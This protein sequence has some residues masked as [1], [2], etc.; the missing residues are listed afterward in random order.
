MSPE[1][2]EDSFLLRLRIYHV[3]PHLPCWTM[4]DGYLLPVDFI[5][6]EKILHLN[7]LSPSNYQSCYESLRKLLLPELLELLQLQVPQELEEQ[8]LDPPQ[9]LQP[10]LLPEFLGQSF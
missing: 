6:N 8:Q 7:V 2:P 10:P 5:L 1:S 3:R 9:W 4:F